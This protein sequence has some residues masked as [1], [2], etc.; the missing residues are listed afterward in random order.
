MKQ[1]M[2][3]DDFADVTLVSDDKKHIKA[4]KNILSACS[5]VLKDI[6]NLERS[7]KPII[8]LK[9]VQ[10]SELESI[11]QFIY[12]GEATF[13]EERM[14]EFIAV[15]KSLEIKE[16]CNAENETNVDDD[17]EQSANDPVASTNTF[18][19]ETIRSTHVMNQTLKEKKDRRVRVNG[20]YECDQ[21]NKTYGS[22]WVLNRHI[23]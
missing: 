13:Y 11:M 15:A 7:A 4:H 5:P 19:E 2:M 10:Y 8:Y 12:L 3:N 9:G 23:E 16:L 17:S 20:K 14:N 18:E 1:L 21:C 6:V 22:S